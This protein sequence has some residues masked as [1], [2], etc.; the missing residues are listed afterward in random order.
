MRHPQTI[1]RA[2]LDRSNLTDEE[3]REAQEEMFCA[4]LGLCVEAARDIA[5]FEIAPDSA[6][7]VG[8]Q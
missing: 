4:V 1:L 5:E 2:V 3:R 8:E 6:R 7:V